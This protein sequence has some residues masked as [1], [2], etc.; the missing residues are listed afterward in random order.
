MS[1][2]EYFKKRYDSLIKLYSKWKQTISYFEDL[3]QQYTN[4]INDNIKIKE[5]KITKNEEGEYIVLKIKENEYYILDKNL[6]DI[7]KYIYKTPLN[8][9]S[10]PYSSNSNNITPIALTNAINWEILGFIFPIIERL[11]DKDYNNL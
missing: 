3:F 4:Y 11:T 9:L 6:Y 5:Y 8:F 2:E 7:V 1:Y 10:K